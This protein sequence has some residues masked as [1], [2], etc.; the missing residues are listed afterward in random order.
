M[1]I[2][3]FTKLILQLQAEAESTVQNLM[4]KDSSLEDLRL[5]SRALGRAEAYLEVLKLL[6]RLEKLEAM[7]H[8]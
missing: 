1:Q 6:N 4:G 3:P 7:G 8:E 2:I 5:A